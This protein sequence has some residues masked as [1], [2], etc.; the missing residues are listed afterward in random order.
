MSRIVTVI[1]VV[2]LCL[3][4]FF[5]FEPSLVHVS[6]T[7][8]SMSNT[9][10]HAVRFTAD[11]AYLPWKQLKL[12]TSHNPLFYLRFEFHSSGSTS[13]TENHMATTRG[14][15]S[16]QILHFPSRAAL[17][18]CL[19]SGNSWKGCIFLNGKCVYVCVWEIK[20]FVIERERSDSVG[21]KM[22]TRIH[23][24]LEHLCFFFLPFPPWYQNA[25][26]RSQR[27]PKR[28]RVISKRLPPSCR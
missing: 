8:Q 5:L 6:R 20:R 9:L 10:S 1:F 4:C 17:H 25:A 26:S 16:K 14:L 3:Y 18:I 28:R 7:M 19:L 2:Q 27:F 13:P 11:G 22:P 12:T 21:E 23:C 24:I 15:F